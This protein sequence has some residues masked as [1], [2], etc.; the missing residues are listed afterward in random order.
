L[1][2]LALGLLLGPWAKVQAEPY[3]DLPNPDRLQP[4]EADLSTSALPTG[5][6]FR[7]IHANGDY[8]TGQADIDVTVDPVA[9]TV[10]ESYREGDVEVREP[11]VLTP[12][13]YNQI[14]SG[15]TVR[16]LWKDKARST[17]S[18]DR[19]Q[20][21][22]G[23]A[24]RV[25]LPVQ[26][27][28]LVRTIVGDGTPNI[29]I[30]GSETITL[31]GTS[32]WTAS[33]RIQ[34]E[35]K[36]QS[37]FPSFDMKQELNVNLTGSIGDRIKIDIDQSSNVTDL[38]RQPGEATV[39][40]R[41]RRHDPLRRARKHEPVR[42]RRVVPAGGAVRD[43]DR[44]PAR[45]PRRAGDREQAGRKD[46]DRAFH[47]RPASSR[48]CRSGTSSTSTGPTSS[49]PTIRSRSGPEPCVCTGTIAFS[50]RT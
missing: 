18:M 32:D 25:E 21:R 8:P 31:S 26:L 30:S 10:Q 33:N 45:Q 16:R 41:R 14:L 36:N 2:I 12:D 7:P 19:G 46:R 3:Q 23:T 11:L 27:P 48:T 43:Q 22:S 40:G 47:P 39:R 24:L 35:R 29:E 34:T 4:V 38:D 17:R 1:Y 13:E 9:G 20:L 44:G 28:K 15:R 5:W 6:R 37:A 50:K 49:S 42:G